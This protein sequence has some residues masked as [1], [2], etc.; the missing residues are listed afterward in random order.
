VRHTGDN[1]LPFIA[2]ALLVAYSPHVERKQIQKLRAEIYKR[3]PDT[4]KAAPKVVRSSDGL[5][6]GREAGK[7]VAINLVYRPITGS[8]SLFR[9]FED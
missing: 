5:H 6:E 1:G 2:F 4:K 9:G 8:K 3:Y 7:R